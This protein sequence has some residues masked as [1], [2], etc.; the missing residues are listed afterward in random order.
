MPLDPH[1][2]HGPSPVEK[3]GAD[4]SVI[5][6][7]GSGFGLLV[8]HVGGSED[9]RSGEELLD[10]P[11][12]KRMEVIEASRRVVPAPR[13][14]PSREGRTTTDAP[15]MVEVSACLNASSECRATATSCN[16]RI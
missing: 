16:L 11:H 2:R 9:L 12:V 8:R 10:A 4:E 5:A 15:P 1:L 14:T 6:S 7:H 13:E 3:G